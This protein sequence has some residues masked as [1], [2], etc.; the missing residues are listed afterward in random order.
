LFALPGCR[1]KRRFAAMTD[2][3][4]ASDVAPEPYG[5]PMHQPA[6]R[7]RPSQAML[8]SGERKSLPKSRIPP[9]WTS[10]ETWG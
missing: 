4:A 6:N 9:A 2:A 10:S 3:T 1:E 5:R 8:S 7:A